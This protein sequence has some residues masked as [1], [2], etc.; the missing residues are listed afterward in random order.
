[1]V[2]AT[3]LCSEKDFIRQV[4]KVPKLEHELRKHNWRKVHV[5]GRK[6][7]D[8]GFKGVDW[9]QG[10]VDKE[11]DLKISFIVTTSEPPEL[12]IR[13]MMYHK[14]IGVSYFYIFT[15][16]LAGTPESRARLQQEPGVKIVNRDEELTEKQSHSRAWKETWLAAFFNKPCNH[17]LFVKQSLNMESKFDVLEGCHW[18]CSVLLA[19]VISI[20]CST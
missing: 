9:A 7:A 8:E 11:H 16:G 17:E 1:V 15:E 12:I 5:G 2:C 19:C 18:S 10:I 4:D 3:V 6:P 14:A 13:W 20:S